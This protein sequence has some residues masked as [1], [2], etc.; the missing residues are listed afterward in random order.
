MRTGSMGE[1]GCGKTGSLYSI[2]YFILYNLFE[3]LFTF[4]L[5]SQAF[6]YNNMIAGFGCFPFFAD[7]PRPFRTYVTNEIMYQKN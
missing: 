7:R 4:T 3:E 6:I 1:Q 2:F 5:F